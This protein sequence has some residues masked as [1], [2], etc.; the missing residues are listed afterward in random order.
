[1]GMMRME[2]HLGAV[3]FSGRLDPIY[4]SLQ[5]TAAGACTLSCVHNMPSEYLM[6]SNFSVSRPSPAKPL[7]SP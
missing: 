7:A 6:I 4:E 2:L 1:M 3:L 5:E